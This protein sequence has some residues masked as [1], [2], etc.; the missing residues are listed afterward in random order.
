MHAGGIRGVVDAMGAKY[1]PT[2]KDMEAA[3]RF[4]NKQ[5]LP[6]SAFKKNAGP[7]AAASVKM[8]ASTA[9]KKS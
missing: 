8:N 7:A 4:Q 2:K 6:K 9:P 1:L 3:R 5:C